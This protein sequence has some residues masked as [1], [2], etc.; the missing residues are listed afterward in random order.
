[1]EH[2]TEKEQSE[3]KD[4]RYHSEKSHSPSRVSVQS[5]G[6]DAF[7][8]CICVV[9]E[10]V[11]HDYSAFMTWCRNKGIKEAS[12]MV[13]TMISSKLRAK[14]INIEEFDEET[15]LLG[16]ELDGSS[17]ATGG[18]RVVH[19]SKVLAVPDRESKWFTFPDPVRRS[20]LCILSEMITPEGTPIGGRKPLRL[21]SQ[22]L[23]SATGR[24]AKTLAL[25][26]PKKSEKF[27]LIAG[28]EKEF[29]IVPNEA[30][31]KRPDLK[32]IGMTV[33]GEPGPINQ[34]LRGVY[35]TIPRTKEEAL[36][37]DI[38]RNLATVGIVAVQ[39]HLEVGQTGNELNGRQCEIV[40]KY[41]PALHAADNELIA[42][43][44]IED[45]CSHH[46]FR[47]LIGSKSFTESSRGDGINGSGKHTNMSL[48]KYNVE[49]GVIVENLLSLEELGNDEKSPVNLIGLAMVAALGRHW[50][51]YDAA[52]ASRGNDLRRRPGY[53]APVYL[54]A[55]IGSTAE[56]RDSLLQDRNRSVSI[57]LSG[58]KLEWRAPGANSPM[59]FPL[60]FVQMGIAELLNEINEKITGAVKEGI[61]LNEAVAAECKRLRKEIDY[62]VV[63]EDVYELGKEDA[64]RRFGY[65][66]PENTFEALQ[67]LDS[68]KDIEFLIQGDVF[69]EEMIR[70][71]KMVQLE[72]Y[73]ERVRAEARVTSHMSKVLG[74]KVLKS[75]LMSIPPHHLAEIEQRLRERQ[76][77]LGKLSADLIMKVDGSSLSDDTSS[78]C[79]DIRGLLDCLRRMDNY[80]EMA[81]LVVSR[82]LPLMADIR[83][84]YEEI[85]EI[86]G[87]SEEVSRM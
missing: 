71:F 60:A 32:Y 8:K 4:M 24:L 23:E 15:F 30:A 74:N 81:S 72:N 73:V 86:I 61:P 42:R 19:R 56:F 33:V 20:S 78:Q 69:T 3:S 39:K 80:D 77:H 85:V 41:A 34:N 83:F 25:K 51:V 27:G 6:E 9:P 7:A 50:P 37:A 47:V 18:G 84:I 17:F 70:A 44:I 48:V 2:T 14:P 59:Y 45:V 46:G 64:E 26:L 36:L 43:Q 22:Y 1:M 76:I 35:L 31:E 63:D 55:F 67:A 11:K 65:K 79:D 13:A 82:L 16:S 87:G 62:F 66:A 52:I 75:P 58:N 54:S 53:E 12:H 5:C 57:G 49:D 29:F 38:V 21:A 68:K 28:F 40:L 10:E